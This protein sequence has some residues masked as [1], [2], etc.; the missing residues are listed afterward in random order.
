M[1]RVSR[2]DFI[3]YG[4]SLCGAAVLPYAVCAAEDD[5]KA[6]FRLTGFDPDLPGSSVFVVTSDIHA[7]VLTFSQMK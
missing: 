6:A 2:R 3:G 7:L 1:E 4:A 5:W